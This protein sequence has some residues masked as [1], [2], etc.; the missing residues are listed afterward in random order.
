MLRRLSPI[1]LAAILPAIAQ[2][3]EDALDLLTAAA[4]K[5]RL[6]ARGYRRV[7]RV[8]R[9]IADL[10]DCDAI[11]RPHIAEAERLRRSPIAR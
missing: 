10:A 2:A 11:L 9:T 5:M 3:E 8:A 1:V 6:T 7:L 4:E